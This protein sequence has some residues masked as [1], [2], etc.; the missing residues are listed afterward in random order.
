MHVAVIGYTSDSRIAKCVHLNFLYSWSIRW[1]RNLENILFHREF[2]D[3]IYGW[4][5]VFEFCS[6][7]TCR[8]VEG[9][10]ILFY[11]CTVESI[12]P[13][14]QRT[15]YQTF[16]CIVGNFTSPSTTQGKTENFN[17]LHIFSRHRISQKL[18]TFLK[19]WMFWNS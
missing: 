13:A 8:W 10:W 3:I 19:L 11:K 2:R 7:S 1:F 14:T 12:E 17:V 9:S 18:P 15:G 5:Y 16:R 6:S 4:L